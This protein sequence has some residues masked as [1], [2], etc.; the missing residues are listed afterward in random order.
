M[1]PASNRIL[2]THSGSLPRP[3]AF[4]PLAGAAA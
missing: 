2:T 1:E 4:L 3:A